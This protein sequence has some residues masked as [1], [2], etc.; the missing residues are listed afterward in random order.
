[1]KNTFGNGTGAA[2]EFEQIVSEHYESL[3]RFAFSLTHS[4][5]D[6]CD[7]TQ[8]TFY[9]WATKGYQLRDHSKVKAWLFTILHRQFLSTRKRAVRFPHIELSETN[10]EFLVAEPERPDKLDAPRV[11]EML[12]QVQEPYQAAVSLFY[13]ED[14]SYKEIARILEVPLG[15]VRSRISRGITQLQKAMLGENPPDRHGREPRDKEE[16]CA[17]ECVH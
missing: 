5:A 12:A 1:M 8:Q 4:E 17:C 3:Y 2:D 9:V 13:L 10:Q 11:R 6:A 14:Y 16:D 15:T 7:L